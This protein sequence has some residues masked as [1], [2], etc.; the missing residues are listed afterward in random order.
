MGIMS[1]R[2]KSQGD[3]QVLGVRATKV[4]PH[5][6]SEDFVEALRQAGARDSL[7]VAL[8]SE[9]KSDRPPAP[10]KVEK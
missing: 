4:R 8:S 7:V 3:T 1:D 6:V 5:E 2:K 10:P 9:R